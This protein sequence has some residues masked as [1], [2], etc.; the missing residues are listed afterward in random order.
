MGASR[1]VPFVSAANKARQAQLCYKDI[2]FVQEHIQNFEAALVNGMGNY[3]CLDRL[4]K[5]RVET[6]FYLK[7]P[8]FTRLLNIV[9]EFELNITGDFETL[10]FTVPNDI[11]SRVNAD[12]DQCAWRHFHLF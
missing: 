2:P 3:I 7:N 5:A 1:K 10:G 6:Q 9:N 11:R 8:D 4:E 12:T